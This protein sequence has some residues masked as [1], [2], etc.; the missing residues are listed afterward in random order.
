M[1][2]ALVRFGSRE[3]V[4]NDVFVELWM[5]EVSH[6]LSDDSKIDQ[7]LIDLKAEWH[8]QATAGFGFGPE[9]SLE[10]F[11]T[12]DERRI[13]LMH[14]FRLTLK[15]LRDRKEFYTPDELSRFGVG[16]PTVLYAGD[17]PTQSVI[18]VGTEFIE[19]LS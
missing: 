1:G 10:T 15:T 6:V 11:V 12:T 7:W 13:R 9:P 2:Y 19:L 5:L 14:Y 3:V 17:I 16:G 8:L 18:D 4:A